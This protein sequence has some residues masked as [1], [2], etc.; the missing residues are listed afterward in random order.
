VECFLEV[1]DRL[2]FT[3]AAAVLYLSQP[4]VTAQVKSLEDELGFPLFRREG[5]TV[6]LTA[7]GKSM[8]RDLR[9]ILTAYERAVQ[10][11]AVLALGSAQAVSLGYSA[12]Q[13]ETWLASAMRL[14]H[15]RHPAATVVLHRE[16]AT[17]L[18]QMFAEGL[19]DAVIILDVDVERVPDVEFV[20]IIETN[21]C[22]FMP[23]THRLAAKDQIELADLK[24]ED[25]IT[26]VQSGGSRRFHLAARALSRFGL[27]LKAVQAID[28]PETGFLMAEAGSG[29]YAG[30]EVEAAFAARFGLVGRVLDVRIPQMSIG[31]A[32]HKGSDGC[33]FQAL[34]DGAKGV[35]ASVDC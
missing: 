35:L 25:L 24:D 18:S 22:M 7:A 16:K 5:H 21:G 1:A 15:A 20:P 34:A 11:A 26:L 3:R 8:Q 29:I 10:A 4:A 33:L 23:P 14:F 12:S 32:Y 28:D 31:I 30:L 13:A 19:L 27:D 2:S 6:S 9:T 17:Q